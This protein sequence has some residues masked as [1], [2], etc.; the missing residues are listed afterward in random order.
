[1]GALV[2]LAGAGLLNGTALVSDPT[3]AT[4]GLRVDMLPD[5]HSWDYRISGLFVLVFLGC[6]PLICA[7][8]IV[9][10]VDGA[11]IVVAGIGTITL[12]WTLWQIVVLDIAAPSAHIGLSLGGIVLVISGAVGHSR[13]STRY[14]DRID[15][16]STR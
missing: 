14:D 3:G 11:S 15:R 6:A 4:L 9:F 7:V 5:W 13:D 1:M 2:L 10:H 16:H 12:V 8:A